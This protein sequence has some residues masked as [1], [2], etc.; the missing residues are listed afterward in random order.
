MYF[1]L[2]WRVSLVINVHHV[3]Y[4]FIRERKKKEPEVEVAVA[5][6]F[7]AFLICFFFFG[8]SNFG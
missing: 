2:Y 8:G 3:Q 5:T 7:A 4:R 6:K 1:H